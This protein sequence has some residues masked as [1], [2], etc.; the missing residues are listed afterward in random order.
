ME[1]PAPLDER[2]MADPEE[3]REPEIGVDVVIVAKK[4]PNGPA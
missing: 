3:S 2:Q 1:V 4:S